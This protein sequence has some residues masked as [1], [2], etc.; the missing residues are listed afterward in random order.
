MTDMSAPVP[1]LREWRFWR[2]MPGGFMAEWRSRGADPRWGLFQGGY[3]AAAWWGFKLLQRF[4]RWG[5]AGLGAE[6][7]L[8][9]RLE[10]A[11]RPVQTTGWLH[12]ELCT[13]RDARLWLL[14]V[15]LW[16]GW[17]LFFVCNLGMRLTQASEDVLARQRR[18]LLVD[19]ARREQAQRLQAKRLAQQVA[20]QR[21]GRPWPQAR[22][23]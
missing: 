14:K 5:E 23:R 19:Q 10:L 12:L 11:L 2:W 18:Q 20:R 6:K 22:A 1:L 7:E 21:Q 4:H 15:K 8:I 3:L 16:P 17:D 13:P 9:F